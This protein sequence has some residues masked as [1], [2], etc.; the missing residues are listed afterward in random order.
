MFRSC[1]IVVSTVTLLYAGSAKL[2]IR[3][4]FLLLPDNAMPEGMKT[5][6]ERKVLLTKGDETSRIRLK[7]DDVSNG[8]LEFVNE[9]NMQSGR[10]EFA[11]WRGDRGEDFI[12]VNTV[13]SG[14]GGVEGTV[15]F[16]TLRG[17]TWQDVTADVFGA[18][19]SKAFKPRAKTSARCGETNVVN[20]FPA[21]FSCTLPRKG[22]TITCRYQAYCDIPD[23]FKETDIYA[24]PVVQFHW[25]KNR[26]VAK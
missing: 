6:A 5:A 12:G 17:E 14:V 2:S 13:Y 21:G 24:K 4:Y 20:P 25:Q 22:L 16:F 19:Q 23:A 26:F 7:V 3:D 18:F 11:I 1:L 8:Y 10:F 15:Q 9:G